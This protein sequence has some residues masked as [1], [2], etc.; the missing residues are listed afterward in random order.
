MV[1][2]GAAFGF[3]IE[4]SVNPVAGDQEKLTAPDANNGVE[5]PSQMEAVPVAVTIGFRLTFTT[6]DSEVPNP[7][8]LIGVTVIVP[9]VLPVVTSIE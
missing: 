3:A 7:Q 5:E 8:L 1:V 6:K 9:P 4:V 2:S